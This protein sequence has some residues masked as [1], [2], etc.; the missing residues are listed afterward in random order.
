MRRHVSMDQLAHE[1]LS[2]VA[3]TPSPTVKTASAES[4]ASEL[5]QLLIKVA[6]EIRSA[7]DDSLSYDDI[8]VAAEARLGKR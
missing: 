1:I 8:A 4:H 7:P 5:A 3:A 2:E 6:N